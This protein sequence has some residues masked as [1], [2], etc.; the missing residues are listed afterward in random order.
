MTRLFPHLLHRSKR[1]RNSRTHRRRLLLEQLEARSLLATFSV[2]NGD[3]AG[4]GS[5]RQAILD[6]NASAGADLIDFNVAATDANHVYYKNDGVAG[7]VTFANIF[8]TIASDD[9]TIADID[10]EQCSSL[11]AAPNPV[12]SV[13]IA[14][15]LKKVC[16]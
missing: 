6:A 5:L 15:P 16:P 11:V 1:A 2:V 8:T 12:C 14:S 4:I 9:S 13:S 7:Q 3:N 10:P